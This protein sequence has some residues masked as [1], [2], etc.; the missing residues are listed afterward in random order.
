MLD[1][2]RRVAGDFLVAEAKE[3]TRFLETLRAAQT[4]KAAGSEKGF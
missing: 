1:I 4:I 2:S 3:Q